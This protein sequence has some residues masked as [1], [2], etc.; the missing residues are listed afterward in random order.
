MYMPRERETKVFNHDL[1]RRSKV[2]KET[3]K[4]RS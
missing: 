4:R 2:R 1:T 3:K